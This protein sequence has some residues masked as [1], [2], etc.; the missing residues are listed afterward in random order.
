MAYWLP[1]RVD[2]LLYYICCCSSS[3]MLLLFASVFVAAVVVVRARNSFAFENWPIGASERAHIH[4]HMCVCVYQFVFIWAMQ[5]AWPT[6]LCFMYHN[7]CKC[8]R[9]SAT[10]VCIAHSLAHSNNIR[11]RVCVC[12]FDLHTKRILINIW[13][14]YFANRC[15]AYAM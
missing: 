6:Y 4:M 12:V 1:Q 7:S 14:L 15:N 8:K 3:V 13:I 9:A 11:T 10:F 2:Q 5:R